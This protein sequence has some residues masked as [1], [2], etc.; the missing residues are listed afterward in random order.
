MDNNNQQHIKT[1]NPNSKSKNRL[2]YTSTKQRAQK[3]SADVYR[4]YKRRTGAASRE[5][6]VHHPEH[7]DKRNKKKVRTSLID[8]GN[9]KDEGTKTAILRFN[10]AKGGDDDMDI[11]RDMDED[12]HMQ[13]VDVDEDEDDDDFLKTK[14][15]F[16]ME[17][18]L[19]K[20]RNGSKMF[21]KLYYNL[22]P[23]VKSLPE[24]LHHSKKIVHLLLSYLLSEQSDPSSPSSIESW[25]DMDVDMDNKD[26]EKK[27]KKKK[28]S[29][30]V[31][32]VT[33]DV[34]HLLSVL[35][36]DMR[37]EIHPYVHGLI[38]PRIIN[39]LINPPTVTPAASDN[40]QK[41][42]TASIDDKLTNGEAQSDIQEYSSPV[43]T[44]TI[45]TGGK[46]ETKMQQRNLN[47]IIIEA[48]FRTISYILRYDSQ[49]IINETEAKNEKSAEG[50]LELMRKHYGATLA[51]KQVFVRRLAAE[52]FAPIIRKLRSNTARKKHIRRVIK[53]LATSAVTSLAN[54]NS[55]LNSSKGIVIPPRLERS[56]DDAVNGV[57]LL[58]F[59]IVRGVPGR[60]H[61]KAN[62]VVKIVLNSLSLADKNSNKKGNNGAN[63]STSKIE[64]ELEMY[65]KDMIYRVVSK[66]I[67]NIRGHIQKTV[68]FSAV[69]DEL[70]ACSHPIIKNVASSNFPTMGLNHIAKLVNESVSHGHGRLL[71]SDDNITNDENAE[72]LSLF[73]KHMLSKEV[74]GQA[75]KNDQI[76]ILSILC[77]TWKVFPD[78]PSFTSRMSYYIKSI[79]REQSTRKME[80]KCS[81]DP[82]LI[83]ANDLLP[84]VSHELAAKQILPAILSNAANRCK[85]NDG[86]SPLGLLHAVATCYL[87]VDPDQ[88]GDFDDND[89]LFY[90]GEE[91][92]SNVSMN[93]KNLLIDY[94]LSRSFSFEA[95]ES[96]AKVCAEFGFVIRIIPFI[97]LI[98]CEDELEQKDM[99]VIERVLKWILTYL[100]DLSNVKDENSDLSDVRL[101]KSLLL[102][103]FSL[104]VARYQ[105]YSNDNKAIEKLLKKSRKHANDLLFNAPKSLLAIKAI[106]KIAKVLQNIGIELNDNQNETFEI[107]N[108]NLC[109]SSHF[110]RVHTLRLLNTYP[111]RQYVINHGDLDLTD[112]LDEETSYKPSNS[113]NDVNSKSGSALRGKCDLIETLLQIE[114]TETNLK[115]ER[116]LSTKIS[117]VE[118]LGRTGQLPVFYAEA[119]SFH[120]FGLMHVKF[121]PLWK[122]SIR[123]I[124]ALASSHDV[125]VWASMETQLTLVMEESFFNNVVTTNSHAE[126]VAEGSQ[127]ICAEY[128]HKLYSQW[129]NSA[130]NNA[131]QFRD[132]ILAA[133]SQ[134]RV[135]RHQTTDKITVFENVWKV[136]EGV[137]QLT[138]K[139]S[140]VIVPIFLQ[141]LHYQYY[142]F[143]DEDSDAREFSL[144]THLEKKG[145]S[146][147]M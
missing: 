94:C 33:N 49:E 114:T 57:A 3:A 61:S 54:E 67:Y 128:H 86:L 46:I 15:T 100:K 81:L 52:A 96:L 74:Y 136:L 8:D 105:S 121:Q 118:I 99:S 48:A 130:G 78:H 107:L 119:A 69:W 115:S 7:F 72:K 73:L 108:Q 127:D 40:A 133:Q 117:R 123:A 75:C 125:A 106:S 34:L 50:C 101:V 84:Y 6:R 18:D 9:N 134:G 83:L 14:T 132:Q 122:A 68:N 29:F 126:N 95:G 63:N 70:Y 144:E 36:R 37:H 79:T 66:F 5:E 77:S 10:K 135:S 42:S 58:L 147:K 2:K 30:V 41:V 76:A 131:G 11:D 88:S 65:R 97:T 145:G 28:G 93:E 12:T 113:N 16:S 87:R 91:S 53:S 82:V 39:D 124:I 129:D 51:H 27:K 141:F 20:N 85:E 35:A 25:M 64:M 90:V 80:D 22:A 138:T 26:T 109:S 59:Y 44:N 98:G 45:H 4:S 31:N 89:N 24:I 111:K 116:I 1:F 143:H 120:M 60:L 139:K 142:F 17:L 103:A 43:S 137:P 146:L 21:A 102:E 92:L 104:I 56:R 23:L 13:D 19:S 110:L 71:R 47:I 140:R 62:A 112:D 38:L 55:N 32:L